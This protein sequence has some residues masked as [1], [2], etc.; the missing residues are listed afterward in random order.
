MIDAH[1]HLWRLGRNGCVWPTSDLGSICRDFTLGDLIAVLGPSRIDG[2][3]LIQSQ[4]DAADTSWL[5]SVAEDH[6]IAGVVGWAD[7]LQPKAAAAIDELASDSRL[8]GLRPMVQD[9]A[10]DWYDS[11]E[12]DEVFARMTELK[13]VLDALVRALH[14]SSL[15][16][17]AVRHPDLTIVIDHGA[18]P[19]PHD[20]GSWSEQIQMI[21]RL[22]NVSCK[23]SGLLTELPRGASIDDVAPVFERLW[24]AFGAE[25]IVWGSDWPVLTLAGTYERWLDQCR[26]LVPALHH[27]AVFDSNA[28]RVYRL[29][30]S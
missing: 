18:K 21:A 17:L 27:Q 24:N 25:R 4:E 11:P 12:L 14:L 6:L 7:F 2:A 9:R 3:I 16:R 29:G 26:S 22:P 23:L 13:L 15:S 1:V 19:N 20:L 30:T 10:Q 28:R 5:M 8:R